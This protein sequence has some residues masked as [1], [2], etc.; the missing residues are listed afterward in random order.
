M[1]KIRMKTPPLDQTE[2]RREGDQAKKLS[3]YAQVEEHGQKVDD[4]EEHSHQEFNMGNDDV[5]PIRETL[6]DASQ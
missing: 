1:I 3:K 2:G 5:I 4:L 6:E